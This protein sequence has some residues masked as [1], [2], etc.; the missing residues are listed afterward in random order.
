M[1]WFLPFL[2]VFATKS[3]LLRLTPDESTQFIVFASWVQD[4]KIPVFDVGIGEVHKKD[5]KKACIMKEKK[6]PETRSWEERMLLEDG[7]ASKS[8]LAFLTFS[9][10]L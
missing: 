9:N 5:V 3:P 6:N 10:T 1:V 2:A 7:H 4:M 8:K